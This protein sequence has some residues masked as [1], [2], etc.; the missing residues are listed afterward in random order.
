MYGFM[1]EASRPHAEW[2][3]RLAG[4]RG[5]IYLALADALEAAVRAGELAPGDRLPPQRAVAERLGVDLTTVTRAYAAARER[6]LVEGSA[7]R[8]TFVRRG[9]AEDDAG[10]VDLG[11]NLPPPPLGVSLGACLQE[12]A[13]AVLAR[14]DAASLMAYHPAAGAAGQRAA[15]AAW[16]GPV[17]GETAAE[18][19][20]VAPGAQ[21]GLAASLF[22]LCRPGD[23]VVAQSLSYPGLRE[24]AER[25]GLK[26][27]ACDADA[28]GL[29]PADLERL[30]AT[31][32]PRAIY[33]IPTM[34]NPTTAT[35]GP[36]RRRQ[37]A[38]IAAAHD[39]WIIE[40]DPYARLSPA[41]HPALAALAP[42]RTVHLSSLSKCLT[43]GLR[44]AFVACPPR[45]VAPLGE[46][47]RAVALMPAPLM[48]AVAAAWIREG[49]AER[50]L[51]G[52]RAEAQARRILAAEAL[53][54]AV[55]PPE[56]LHV[57]LPLAAP[58][59]AAR[60]AAA[61]LDRGLAVAPGE[62][63]AVAG[64]PH[65]EGIRLCLGGPARRPVL[66]RALT[67]LA[68]LA[69]SGLRPRGVV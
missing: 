64:A 5:P 15:G 40:D 35:M 10:R 52:V 45:L 63:F 17:L 50:L 14:T 57:W 16:L 68:G 4:A 66:A 48:A 32:R 33:A 28:E 67:D 27:L 2:L 22:A 20:L 1:I 12:T 3:A 11:M 53:P 18:R 56:S 37:V 69:G 58:G 24:A 13:A 38:R 23:A 30:C 46:A 65:P 39:V 26:L 42:E 61:A 60:L 19:I 21:A 6:G 51:G 9:A 8:G 7:G 34:Q 36:E 44:I 49:V 62:A 59:E 43:P 31:G 54:A 41:P 55:G 47:L 29:L 25:L